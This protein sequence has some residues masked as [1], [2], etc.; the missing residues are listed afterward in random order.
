[1]EAAAGVQDIWHADGYIY[2]AV[3]VPGVEVFDL[4]DP[5]LPVSLG[6]HFLG[7]SA[8]GV[9][10]DDGRLW[11]TNTEA[12]MVFDLADPAKPSLMAYEE[13][14]DWALNVFA[15]GNIGYVSD[16]D[17]M[18]IMEFHPD[19]QAAEIDPHPENI[20][21]VDDSDR[22]RSFTITNRG[23]A[24]LELVGLKTESPAYEVRIE[25]LSLAPGEQTKGFVVLK[26][27]MEATSTTLC[28]ASNDPD[29][30]VKELWVGKTSS[31]EHGA[32]VGDPAPDF[33]LPELE[34]GQLYTLSDYFGQPIFLC[35]FS[36]W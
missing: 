19:R 16:W 31:N 22:A 18:R 15:D 17:Y 4:A 29:E 34:T 6:T 35:F 8:T 27:G 5:A 26:D 9:S 12:V 24:T 28:I 20:Y 21:F 23:N 11:V 13:T 36:S 30:S 10:V 14:S 1:V 7:P 33:V 25:K 3:G 2:A 32:H